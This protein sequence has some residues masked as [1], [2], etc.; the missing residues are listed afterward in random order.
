MRREILVI[1]AAFGLVGC[2]AVLGLDERSLDPTANGAVDAETDDTLDDTSPTTDASDETL[3]SPSDSAVADAVADS[4]GTDDAKKDTTTNDTA[5]ADTATADTTAIDTAPPDTGMVGTGA[6]TITV[7]RISGADVNL[8]AEGALD[9]AHWGHGTVTAFTHRAAFGGLIQKGD[10]TGT[11]GITALSNKRFVWSDGSPTPSASTPDGLVFGTPGEGYA[12]DVAAS[13][14]TT[15]TLRVYVGWYRQAGGT[16][17]ATLSDGSAAPVSAPSAGNSLGV[18]YDRV[19]VTFRSATA[20]S[21]LKIKAVRLNTPTTGGSFDFF[22]AT[23][24]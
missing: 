1:G 5:M 21:T 13:P 9:W 14:T 24:Q 23:L 12:F 22:A 4:T 7:E 2:N 16:I 11:A 6:L 17:S 8:T 19:V 20:A 18:D 3:P 10:A 15:R